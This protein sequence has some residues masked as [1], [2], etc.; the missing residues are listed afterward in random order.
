MTCLI[1]L[2]APYDGWRDVFPSPQTPALPCAGLVVRLAAH[3]GL[4]TPSAATATARP[5]TGLG[6]SGCSPVLLL[7]IRLHSVHHL[8]PVG[9]ATGTCAPGGAN[10]E[11]Y[12]G[13]QRR[14]LHGLGQQL[15]PD[16]V[17]AGGK[18]PTGRRLARLLPVRDAGRSSC[19]TRCCTASRS[20][21]WITADATLRGAGS[22]ADRFRFE[23]AST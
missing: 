15:N 1:G 7:Q 5:A 23:P 19:R 6:A 12:L 4:R 17:P 14:D 3:H 13:T 20:R 10:E 16:E 18:E 8:H 2:I 11:A 21:R 9:A 22:I